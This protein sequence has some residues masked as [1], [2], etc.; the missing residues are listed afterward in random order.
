MNPYEVLCKVI[1][2]GNKELEDYTTN[3]DFQGT[4]PLVLSSLFRKI[5]ELSDGVRVCAETGLSG[6]R[7]GRQDA[8]LRSMW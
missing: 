7:V 4:H 1:G 8:F 6:P 5:I 2:F 3:K